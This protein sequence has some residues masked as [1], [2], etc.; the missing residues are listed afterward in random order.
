[1][2]GATD[3]PVV[4]AVN[5]GG[6]S[7]KV[8]MFRGDEQLLF[9]DV[10][11]PAEEMRQFNTAYDQLEMRLGI[12]RRA[13]GEHSA[14]DQKVDAVAGRGGPV[15]PVP[16]GT[17]RVNGALLAAIR[18]GRVMVEHPS[19]L[20]A[21]M[22][23][24]L[25]REK[26]CPAF[27]VDPVS[28][29]EFT[30]EARVTGLPEIARRA[31]SHALSIK[32]AAREASSRLGRRFEDL[33]LIVAH[34]GSGFTVAAERRG[35]Q[36][37]STDA[38]ASGSM[39]PNRTGSLPALDLVRFACS[40][41]HTLAELERIL[42]GGGGWKA[43]LGTD[44]LKEIYRRIDSGESRAGLVLDAT[45]Y[46]LSKEIAGMAATLDGKVDAI[47][48]SGGVA[49]SKRFTDE[50]EKRIEWLGAQIFVIPGENEMVALARGAARVLRGE[51]EAL[52]MAPFIERITKEQR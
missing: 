19:L 34:L 13:L 6:T 43:H 25:G 22:A 7:T 8:A 10:R 49:G 2:A 21:P 1:M 32:A 27:V 23:D 15:A 47:A 3:G 36:I 26:D 24:A 28:V 38:S 48:I 35:R 46:Q 11:H 51:C 9:D 5:P 41:K 20:G 4:L 37:D 40:G 14:S 17:F 39:A 44:D 12:V 31:L 18:E 16:C 30:D 45:F 42:V 33:N 29:D 50:L 52:D